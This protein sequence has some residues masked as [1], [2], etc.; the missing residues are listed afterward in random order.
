MITLYKCKE[1]KKEFPFPALMEIPYVKGTPAL[2][3]GEISDLAKRL[4]KKPCCVY[5]YSI[6]IEEVVEKNINEKVEKMKYRC[7]SCEKEFD[8]VGWQEEMTNYYPQVYSSS[9]NYQNPNTSSQSYT[10]YSISSV[11]RVPI[12][13]LCK[14]V[15][16]EERSEK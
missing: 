10:N 2:A 5:C 13:P 15:E 16:I 7:R 14:S 1:C 6:D 12:C 8:L 4:I 11:I 9:F 3:D